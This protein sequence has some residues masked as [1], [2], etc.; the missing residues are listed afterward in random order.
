ML[1][2]RRLTRRLGHATLATVFL[3]SVTTIFQSGLLAGDWNQ[4]RGP[5]GNGIAEVSGT[6]TE[7]SADHFAW[8]T[9]IPGVGWSSPVI[10]GNQI[11]L[12]TAETVKASEEQIAQKKKD[13]QFAQIKTAAGQVTLRAICVNSDDGNVIHDI[14]LATVDN[15]DLINPLNSY[16]S[17][18][19]VIEDDNVICH[20]GSYGTWSLNRDSGNVNWKTALVIDHS[21]GP[22]SSPV[23]SGDNILIVCDGIDQQYVAAL[24]V[25]TGKQKW[26]TD[27][28][29]IK[30]TNGEF[31]KAYSTPLIIEVDGQTQAIIPGAQ[32]MCAYDPNSGKEIWRAD[33]GNGFSTTPMA[34]YASGLVICSTGFMAPELVAINP[35]GAGDITQSNIVWRSKQGG[36]TM[37]TAVAQSGLLY[38]ISDKGVLTV[39]NATTGKI[40]D[41]QRIGGKFASSPLLT[42]DALYLGSQE[43]VMTVLKPGT[44]D[45]L[46][47]TTMDSALMASPAVIGT[48]MIVRTEKMLARVTSK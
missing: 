13:V 7:F 10:A 47:S 8:Q 18:T 30:A 19:S 37:P 31:R 42:N 11:W 12:T 15:P 33:C 48:D 25:V 1:P 21:V 23:I 22:G 36:S 16:A 26:K 24:D 45:K 44:L 6:P 38:S 46:A 43:G 41:R 3:A 34:V 2:N 20:F 29:P 35:A 14:K 9:E 32:W 17:P 40:E 28:P 5:T 27:R 39:L 4:F